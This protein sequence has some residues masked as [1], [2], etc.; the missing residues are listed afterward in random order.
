MPLKLA[1]EYR[2]LKPEN[3]LLPGQNWLNPNLP[4]KVKPAQ[5]GRTLSTLEEKSR[6]QL[7]NEKFP[8]LALGLLCLVQLEP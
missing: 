4:P 7:N 6:N 5:G 2:K 1:S 8:F 3:N